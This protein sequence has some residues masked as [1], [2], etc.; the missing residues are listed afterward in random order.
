M[1]LFMLLKTKEYKEYIDPSVGTAEAFATACE[2]A[3]V[4]YSSHQM[5]R[6][7][8]VNFAPTRLVKFD[9]NGRNS[10]LQLIEIEE[11]SA[12][13]I[14]WCSLSYVWGGDQLFKTTWGTL[15]S[16]LRGFM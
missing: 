5:C 13:T 1:A 15:K 2:W 7:E 12:D 8:P 14:Q 10:A 16:R 4:C 11:Q 3:R 6:V 9:L